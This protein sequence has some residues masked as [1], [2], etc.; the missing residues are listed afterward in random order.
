ML[1]VTHR[2]VNDVEQWVYEDKQV[3]FNRKWTENGIWH[4]SIGQSELV[5]SK[6]GGVYQV[7]ID[8]IENYKAEGEWN[9]IVYDKIVGKVISNLTY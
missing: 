9:I 2:N 3:I 1:I 6:L 5:L 4:K 7:L 8:G